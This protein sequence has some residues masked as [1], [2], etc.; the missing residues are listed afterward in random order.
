MTAL[1]PNAFKSVIDIDLIGS[2]NTVKA[3][4]PHLIRS[5]SAARESR[6]NN[7]TRIIFVSATI[8]YTGA[9]LQTHVSAAKAGVDALS[10][11]CALEFGPRGITSNVIAPGPIAG[12]E[13]VDRLVRKE[14]EGSA[15][16]IIPLGR[17]GTVRE[18]ADA[19]VFLCGPTGSYMNGSIVV[20]DGGAWRL[21]NVGLPGSGFPYPD[22]LLGDGRVEGVG[23][24]KTQGKDSKL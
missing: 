5:A 20:V 7:I 2:Y 11:A 19:T 9:P 8:H 17:F 6:G 14:D 12:T 22:F 13:G 21:S 3:T 10:A 18:I 23:G 24:M 4:L 1:S 16:K 15:G